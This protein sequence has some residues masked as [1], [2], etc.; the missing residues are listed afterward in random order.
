MIEMRL[1]DVAAVTGGRLHRASG[2]ERVASVEFD[3]RAAGP[4]ALFLALPGGRADGH[5]FAA[6]AVAAGASGVLAG[7]EVDAPAVVVPPAP[8]GGHFAST[9][10]AAH[11]PDG[12]GAAV[13]AA[14]AALASHAVR[15]LPT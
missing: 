9:Y 6:A 13:L 1:A 15:S 10:L 12:T 4:G 14:L 5:G 8:P 11:D 7:R 3:S 2:E